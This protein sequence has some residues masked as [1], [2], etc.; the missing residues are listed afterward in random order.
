MVT[1]CVWLHILKFE[2]LT[3]VSSH[4]Q[5]CHQP[6]ISRSPDQLSCLCT[7]AMPGSFSPES[8]LCHSQEVSLLYC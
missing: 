7:T 2:G 8:D 5:S 4:L 3:P 6:L 1:T